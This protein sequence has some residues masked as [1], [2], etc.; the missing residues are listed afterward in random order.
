[1]SKETETSQILNDAFD[2]DDLWEIRK[3]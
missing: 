2:L 3:G 1:M